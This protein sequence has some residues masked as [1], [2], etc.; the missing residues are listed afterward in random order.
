MTL[1]LDELRTTL[2]AHLRE[3]GT[4]ATMKAQLR[5]TILSQVA[6]QGVLNPPPNLRSPSADGD[7][8]PG[9]AAQ[10]ADALVEDYLKKSGRHFSH[11][12]YSAEV[13]LHVTI[14]EADK[15]IG[16][17]RPADGMS[18][19]ASLVHLLESVFAYRSDAKNRQTVSTQTSADGDAPPS[20]EHRLAIVD[21]QYALRCSKL[22]DSTRADIQQ[23][24]DAFRQELE[25]QL[26][27]E[28]ASKIAH[29][30]STELAQMRKEEELRYHTIIGHKKQEWAEMERSMQCRLE[31]ERNRLEHLKK[32]IDLERSQLDRRQGELLRQVDDRDKY[33]LSLE[34]QLR[35]LREKLRETQSLASQYEEICASRLAEVENVKAR[36]QRRL[37]EL[38]RLQAEQQFELRARDEEL[39]SLRMKLRVTDDDHAKKLMQRMMDQQQAEQRREYHQQV[40]V[41]QLNSAIAQVTS[42]AGGSALSQQQHGVVPSRQQAS[43]DR[44]DVLSSQH[45]EGALKEDAGRTRMTATQ[46]PTGTAIAS[47]LPVKQQQSPGLAVPQPVQ[48]PVIPQLSSSSTS[49]TPSKKQRPVIDVAAAQPVSGAVSTA[50]TKSSTSLS[51]SVKSQSPVGAHP[52][53]SN[54]SDSPPPA[55]TATAAEEQ[56]DFPRLQAEVVSTETSRRRDIEMNATEALLELVLRIRLARHDAN[57]VALRHRI[58][59]EEA[60]EWKEIQ[61]EAGQ[62]VR[63]ISARAAASRP[64]AGARQVARVRTPSPIK[65]DSGSDNDIQLFREDSESF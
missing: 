28:V 1:T 37:E 40:M 15:Y 48:Q 43:A 55:V 11:S 42:P 65:T 4:L 54:A 8:I 57:E 25:A 41:Q 16:I 35:G 46:Q 14:D 5:T 10:V 13:P 51:S 64:A 30:R 61:Y 58:G 45:P 17:P 22:Q 52:Q 21:A 31:S 36:E 53:R 34:E 56:L 29:L 50:Q 12:V 3:S 63:N 44:E 23:K 24:I 6:K 26:R 9:I 32:E 27:S 47:V 7:R 39:Q 2:Q 18:S 33:A 49:T 38:R 20:L 60:H 59:S 19:K 62:S